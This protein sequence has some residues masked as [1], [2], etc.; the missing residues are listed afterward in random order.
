MDPKSRS[1]V[2]YAFTVLGSTVAWIP[3]SYWPRDNSVR[4]IS[5]RKRNVFMYFSFIFSYL[6]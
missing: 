2:F 4:S 3:T 6:N 5:V 1:L